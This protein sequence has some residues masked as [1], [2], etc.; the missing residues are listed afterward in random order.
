MEDTA[1]KI[2][3]IGAIAAGAYMALKSKKS[4]ED[5]F[6][7]GN[8]GGIGGSEDSS[9]AGKETGNDGGL[10][11]N[12]SFPAV[13]PVSIFRDSNNTSPTKQ[14]ENTSIS[15]ISEG[16]Q[17]DITTTKKESLLKTTS[18]AL[19]ETYNQAT[20]AMRIEPMSLKAGSTKKAIAARDEDGQPWSLSN[21]SIE[22]VKAYVG[23][24]GNVANEQVKKVKEVIGHDNKLSQK[25]N[26]FSEYTAAEKASSKSETSL[27]DKIKGVFISPAYESPKIL[28]TG[29]NV[30][31]KLT[32][33][34]IENITKS[35]TAWQS[36]SVSKSETFD[37]SNPSG[38]KETLLT[39]KKEATTEKVK[40]SLQDA[41]SRDYNE[42]VSKAS[43]SS[44]SSSKKP[45][46]TK[47]TASSSSSSSGIKRQ[48][49]SGTGESRVKIVRKK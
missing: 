46:T 44:S 36:G 9:F 2:I 37:P 43:G 19:S 14:S 13:D 47:K 23:T 35:P 32:S 42:M 34:I 5:D 10:P 48:G 38:S 27:F 15:E 24:S 39:S 30:V 6:T 26:T 22:N 20:K 25:G 8:F 45:T 1:K 29:G 3:G 7:S 41:A 18:S 4:E 49:S 31:G 28:E 17:T 16:N 33:P 12:I 21:N 40:V 11:I